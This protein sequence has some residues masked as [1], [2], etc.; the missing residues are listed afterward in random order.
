MSA[1]VIYRSSELLAINKPAGV[2][3][4]ADRSGAPN[5]WDQLLAE[6]ATSRTRLYPVHRLDKGTSGVLLM[7]LSTAAQA[8]LNR[9]F[10]ARE[11]AKFYLARVLGNPALDGTT[12]CID[13]P[14]APGRKSRYRIAGPRTSIKR[15]ANVWRLAPGTATGGFDS[16]S[17]IRQLTTGEARTLLLVQPRTGRSHQL[18]VHLSWIGH[19][20]LG[21]TLYGKPR[22]PAQRWPR[23]ALHCHRLVVPTGTG[24][25][26]L[27]APVPADL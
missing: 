10:A 3:L 13:L 12:G 5:L 15:H 8:R 11:V 21:D 26:T 27:C 4:F 20:I 17:R 23:L 24:R 6:F 25:L 2:S 19:P 9:A 18:R 7:A 16:V 14:L 22:E 1:Q